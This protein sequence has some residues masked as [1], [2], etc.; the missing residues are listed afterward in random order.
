VIAG[1]F[2]VQNLKTRI[3]MFWQARNG[4][5]CSSFAD[6]SFLARCGSSRFQ[7]GSR[8]GE[9]TGRA[10]V[11]DFLFGFQPVLNV[12]T[13]KVN[14]FETKCFATDQGDR[15]RFDL[16]DVP[17]DLFTIHELFGRGMSEDNVSDLV[18]CG[19]VLVQP[20]MEKRRSPLV[21][22]PPFGPGFSRHGVFRSDGGWAGKNELSR[23]RSSSR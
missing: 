4:P 1:D 22:I 9:Y 18:E 13:A 5:L 17:C 14:A 15:L 20:E 21:S 23:P 16:A 10:V 19:F 8:S 11:W 12:A 7:N 6:S 3:H 2:L